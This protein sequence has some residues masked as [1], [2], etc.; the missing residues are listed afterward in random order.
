MSKN[1][2]RPPV[3]PVEK[4][5]CQWHRDKAIKAWLAGKWDLYAR[6]IR[7]ADKFTRRG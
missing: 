5:V 4:N 7:I 2:S 1:G 6:H 3:T